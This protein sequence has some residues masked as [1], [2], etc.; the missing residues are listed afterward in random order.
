MAALCLHS[1]LELAS[2]GDGDS[3]ADGANT[4]GLQAREKRFGG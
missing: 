1:T 4:V 3:L 2:G